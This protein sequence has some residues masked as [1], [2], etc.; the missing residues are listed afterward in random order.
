MMLTIII[1]KGFLIQFFFA[2]WLTNSTREI[3]DV[4]E[5]NSI[6]KSSY[7]SIEDF[8]RREYVT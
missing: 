3:L 7:N 8:N 2:N 1:L 5:V 4:L 6:V